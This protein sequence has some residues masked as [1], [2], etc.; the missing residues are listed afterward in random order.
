[1][2]VMATIDGFLTLVT[3]R[4][5]SCSS[6]SKPL[7]AGTTALWHPTRRR[8]RCHGAACHGAAGVSS[9][10][11]SATGSARHPNSCANQGIDHILDVAGE[12]GFRVLTHRRK[13]RTTL[14]MD[15]IVIADEAVTVIDLRERPDDTHVASML[16]KLDD[17]RAVIGDVPVTGVVNGL[18]ATIGRSGQ[19]YGVEV[20]SGCPGWLYTGGHGRG[21]DLAAGLTA[22]LAAV[23]PARD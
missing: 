3:T 14:V 1:M 10:I 19:R 13:P 22:M 17:V 7:P 18:G 12:F 15:I 20:V 4:D 2:K 11:E 6:C 16:R 21:S 9:D 5:G 8:L 23:F